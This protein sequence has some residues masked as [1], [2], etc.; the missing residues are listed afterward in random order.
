M[1]PSPIFNDAYNQLYRYFVGRSGSVKSNQHISKALINMLGDWGIKKSH[2]PSKDGRVYW[3]PMKLGTLRQRFAANAG[4][5]IPDDTPA[6]EGE[7][8]PDNEACARAWAYWRKAG[9]TERA[10]Y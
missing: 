1:L 3:F 9:L 6:D 5:P 8:K 2:Q 7:N 4:V 10:D